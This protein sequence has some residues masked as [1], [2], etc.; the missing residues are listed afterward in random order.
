MIG[1]N[2]R[3]LIKNFILD[4]SLLFTESSL[5]PSHHPNVISQI[6]Q[7][8]NT[9]QKIF[10]NL[11]SFEINVIEKQFFFQDIPLYE[12]QNTVEK[13]ALLLSEKKIQ[14][15]FFSPKLR[16][17]ELAAFVNI[18]L[19]KTK[20]ASMEDF[21]NT[22]NRLE[23]FNIILK[24]SLFIEKNFPIKPD[25]IYGSSIEANKF[26]YN[27]LKTGD[28]IPIDLV[29]KIAQDITMM[30]AKDIYSSLAFSSLHNYDEYTFTHS[31][32]VA[33]LAVSLGSTIIN[34]KD[35]LNQ[36]AKA[37]LLHDIGKTAIPIELLN[38]QA[39][40]TEQDWNILKQHPLLG[41]RI[42]E[43]HGDIDKL[44]V[45]IAAQHHMKY[46]LTGYPKIK[47]IKQLHPLS[48]IV[49]IAD[50]YDA[51]T[52]KRSY[53]DPLPPDKALALMIRFI[54]IDF[55]PRFFKM[56]TQ[57]MGI[58]PP[59]TFIRLNTQEIAVVHR[60]HPDN[61]LLPEIKIIISASGEILTEP[62]QLK[63]FDK[64]NNKTKC[65]IKDVVDTAVLGIDPMNFI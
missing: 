16:P 58:Y 45:L 34:D 27:T 65:Y 55:D 14:R 10:K 11:G 46:D 7:V 24:K 22:L 56:F 35:I 8:Y 47:K 62:K 28:N 41:V 3:N 6:K 44:A 30:I 31:A 32:N 61:I 33:I 51:I 60:I 2:N 23:I 40:L 25:K 63:L 17:H 1:Y 19:E 38:K 50:V 4:L 39:P 9:I 20:P 52:S 54:G 5:Y 18:N 48:L 64:E 43:E 13:T 15:I 57:I 37:A 12:I 42:L 59:G 36:L 49:N 21:Q 53:K 26:I 29:D